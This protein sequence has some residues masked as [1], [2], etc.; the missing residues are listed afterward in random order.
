ML[1]DLQQFVTITSLAVVLA[2]PLGA[3]WEAFLRWLEK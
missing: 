2:V 3:L 1:A